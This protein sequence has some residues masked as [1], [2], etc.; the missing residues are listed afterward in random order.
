[1]AIDWT[2]FTFLATDGDK[3]IWTYATTHVVRDKIQLDLELPK[4][5]KHRFIEAKSGIVTVFDGG[6]TKRVVATLDEIAGE[7]LD[8]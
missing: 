6:F 5:P 1:M 4:Y 2:R 8:H 7:V 3:S